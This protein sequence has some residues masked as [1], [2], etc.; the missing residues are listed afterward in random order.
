M[1]EDPIRLC[2][3]RWHAHLDGRLDR[4][5]ESLLH[6]DCVF[7]S[8]IVFTPQQGRAITAL[9]LQAA[10][11]SLGGEP[12]DDDA[13]ADRDSFRYVKEIAAGHQAVLEF[14]TTIDG[15]YANGVDIITCDADSLI[16]EFKVMI[17]PLQ[18]VNAV[19]AQMKAMLESLTAEPN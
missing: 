3:Q 4:G 6:E 12:S 19:H 5:F 17:R 1:S 7:L 11:D 18:A 10:F 16:T 13:S 8:P 14:E 9:Y 15:K 2:L